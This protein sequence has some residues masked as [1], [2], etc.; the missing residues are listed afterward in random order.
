MDPSRSEF[1]AVGVEGVRGQFDPFFILLHAVSDCIKRKSDRIGTCEVTNGETKR[2]KA[3]A[4]R[5]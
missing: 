4:G 1:A 3:S 5:L 2:N